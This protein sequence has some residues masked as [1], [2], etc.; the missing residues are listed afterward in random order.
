MKMPTRMLQKLK[1]ETKKTTVRWLQYQSSQ[2]KK[3]RLR[4][5]SR[6]IRKSSAIDDLLYTSRNMEAVREQMLQVNLFKL[7]IEVH[8]VYKVLLPQNKQTRNHDDWFDEIDE[9]IMQFK[10]KIHSWIRE[11]EMDRDDKVMKNRWSASESFA[12]NKK[13]AFKQIIFKLKVL[14]EALNLEGEA[15]DGRTLCRSSIHGK[16]AVS[17]TRSPET[18]VWRAVCQIKDKAE[19]LKDLEDVNVEDIKDAILNMVK[20]H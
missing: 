15:V 16:E 17:W 6:M 11:A 5:Y 7:I 2:L 12:S 14:E 9:K 10:H 3:K 18:E 20:S 4:L 13:Q 1:R 8:N 19:D